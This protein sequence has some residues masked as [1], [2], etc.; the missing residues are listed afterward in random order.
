MVVRDKVYE[1][2]VGFDGRCRRGNGHCGFFVVDAIHEWGATCM[3]KSRSVARDSDMKN[4]DIL[5]ND[6]RGRHGL[7]RGGSE[8]SKSTGLALGRI[9]VA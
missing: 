1:A 9:C 6:S 8:S 4:I 7:D 3:D 2:L 5:E